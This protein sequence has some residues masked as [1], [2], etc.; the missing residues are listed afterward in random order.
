MLTV[1]GRGIRV[2]G[3]LLRIARLDGDKYRFLDDP[4]PVLANLRKSGTRIDLFTFMQRLPGTSPKC[5]YPMEWD[6]LAAVPVSTFDHWWTKQID[7]KTRNMVRKGE[8]KGV[9]L[10]E[11][12]FD[13]ALV[14][15]IWEIYNETPVRR[16]W[17][18]ESGCKSCS[19]RWL[20]NARVINRSEQ[21]ASHGRE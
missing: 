17:R 11:V 3:R 12:P 20:A 19:I 18:H 16:R 21:D 5:A 13:D 10:R 6:N 4:E 7:N 1:C 14:Q 9:T 2:E 8:K 15:G